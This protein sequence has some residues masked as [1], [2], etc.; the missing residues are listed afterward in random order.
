MNITTATIVR[1]EAG[2]FLPEAL[3]IWGEFS[4]RI[5][6]LDND[7]EDNTR[8]VAEAAGAEVLH[9]PGRMWGNESHFRKLLF[10]EARARTP[11]DG[12]IFILDADMVPTR[13]PTPLFETAAAG[14]AFPLYDVWYVYSDGFVTYR[15]DNFW[16][17]HTHPRLWAVKNSPEF[18]VNP[19]WPPRGI[20]CGHFPINTALPSVL[21]APA[22]YGL[23]HFAYSTPELRV[24][25]YKQ[26]AET[27]SLL[28]PIEKA[29]VASILEPNPRTKNLPHA[30]DYCLFGT[31]QH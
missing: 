24:E 18:F 20:H 12:W 28:S 5:L 11:E 13:D 3:S 21:Y 2:K 22:D 8:E 7:S 30:N 9:A 10:D 25:K 15:E 16:Q 27:A 14:L 1:N 29:H 26:Y 4:S 23:L 17:G 31:Q 6:V 19:E